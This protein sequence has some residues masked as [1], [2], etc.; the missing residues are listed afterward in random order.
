[1]IILWDVQLTATNSLLAFK[2]HTASK[3]SSY[4]I[5][6]GAKV[7]LLER[8]I[9][10]L[11]EKSVSSVASITKILIVLSASSESFPTQYQSLLVGWQTVHPPGL[12]KFPVPQP[13]SQT[14]VSQVTV[15]YTLE[16]STEIIR[17]FSLSSSKPLAK[18]LSLSKLAVIST[19]VE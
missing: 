13:K 10:S 1:M 15:L 5:H 12:I 17:Y 14:E 8:V 7:P 4:T 11:I 3:F 19:I 2:V 18:I 6:W 9:K 16:L